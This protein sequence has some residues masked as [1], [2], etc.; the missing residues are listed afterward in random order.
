MIEVVWPGRS[1]MSNFGIVRRADARTPLGRGLKKIGRRRM[2][3]SLLMEDRG[4]R[5]GLD[6]S[7]ADGR[8]GDC[9]M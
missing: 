1:A 5:G 6:A 7:C 9:G 2:R 4:F 3:V 8:S